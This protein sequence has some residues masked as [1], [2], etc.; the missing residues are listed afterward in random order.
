M[1]GW[2][3]GP[4]APATGSRLARVGEARFVRPLD[5]AFLSTLLFFRQIGHRRCDRC[6]ADK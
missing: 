1:C 2:V 6:A 4:P 5:Y 3:C